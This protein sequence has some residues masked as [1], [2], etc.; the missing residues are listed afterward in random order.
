MASIYEREYLLKENRSQLSGF[1]EKPINRLAIAKAPK[2]I[3]NIEANHIAR[4]SISQHPHGIVPLLEYQLWLE[5]GK[6]HENYRSEKND[7][8]INFNSNVWRNFRTS[9]GFDT[10]R[11]GNVSESISLLYPINI[12]PPSKVGRYT[13]AEYF[14]QNKRGF[15]RSD[16]TY[17]LALDKVKRE[18]ALMKFLRLKSDARN[19][20]VDLNGNI[21]P[22]ENFKR[23]PS[24][25][26]PH[27]FNDTTLTN[28]NNNPNNTRVCNSELDGAS[29]LNNYTASL[30]Q[31]VKPYT[32]FTPSKISFR[33][34]HP[35]YERVLLEQQIKAIEKR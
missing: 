15:F 33:E 2:T 24:V 3:L 8:T 5:A 23:Y 16:K 27:N 35:N 20:P 10:T 6:V 22:P 34:T 4:T 21:L 13:L 31:S 26:L 18:D 17:E 28:Q 11:K 14:K 29:K 1:T 9:C 12:P 25:Q 7:P 30:S 19:P 32:P